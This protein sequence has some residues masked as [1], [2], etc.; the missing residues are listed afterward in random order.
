MESLESGQSQ[1]TQLLEKIEEKLEGFSQAAANRSTRDEI[2]CLR[3]DLLKVL[4]VDAVA[5]QRTSTPLAGPSTILP[6]PK[7]ESSSTPTPTALI[8]FFP[9]GVRSNKRPGDEH[10]NESNKKR[11]RVGKY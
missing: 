1:Q 6:A 3:Q 2:L 7:L 4:P 11:R 9:D 8:E 5:H 10:H